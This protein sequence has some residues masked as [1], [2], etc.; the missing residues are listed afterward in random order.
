[1]NFSEEER[2]ADYKTAEYALKRYNHW[3]KIRNQGQRLVGDSSVDE[4]LTKH[5]RVLLALARKY[6]TS[7]MYGELLYV[8]RGEPVPA[9]CE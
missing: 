4:K 1:M 9:I 8:I 5:E 3:L 6:D 7:H 2:K